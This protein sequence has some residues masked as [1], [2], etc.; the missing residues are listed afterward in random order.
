MPGPNALKILHEIGVADEVIPPIEHLHRREN[1]LQFWSSKEGH[2]LIYD[3]SS[4]VFL[5]TGH[6]AD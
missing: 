4:P 6:I 2:E 3:A 1:S 5:S